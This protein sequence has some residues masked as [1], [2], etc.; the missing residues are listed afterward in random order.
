MSPRQESGV[1]VGMAFDDARRLRH[2]RGCH[3]PKKT[4]SGASGAKMAYRARLILL[5]GTAVIL[6]LGPQTLL[7][8]QTATPE[9]A[10]AKTVRSFY[11]FHLAHKK[12]FTVS[13]V[14]LRKGWLTPELYKLLLDEL[15]RAAAA[16]KAHPDEAP[17]FEGD[18]LTDSQEYPSSFRTGKSEVSGDLAKVTVTL[19]WS[20]GTSRGRDSRDIV[21]EVKRTETGW[22][23]NDIISNQ[24]SRLSDELKREH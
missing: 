23:I 1:F 3:D 7:S 11:T 4:R 5:I 19:L 22:L 2:A 20:A 15:K 14:R 21:V 9:A 6:S 8:G 18:P 16:S 17:D 13:N 12:G 10:A 24:G